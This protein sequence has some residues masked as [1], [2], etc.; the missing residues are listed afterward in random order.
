MKIS[1]GELNEC[2]FEFEELHTL[3]GWGGGGPGKGISVY[4]LPIFP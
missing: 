3:N 4:G 1:S 2:V